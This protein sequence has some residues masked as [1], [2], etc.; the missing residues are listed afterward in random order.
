M[1]TCSEAGGVLHV[2]LKLSFILESDG[3]GLGMT[4]QCS[5][6]VVGM[7]SRYVLERFFFP[8]DL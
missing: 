1:R 4:P 6:K 8:S 5:L 2:C 3:L 7:F